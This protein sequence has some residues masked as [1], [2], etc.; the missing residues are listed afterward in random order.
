MIRILFI[1]CILATLSGCAI[2]D[3]MLLPY[4]R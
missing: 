3:I 2:V 4:A 1:T